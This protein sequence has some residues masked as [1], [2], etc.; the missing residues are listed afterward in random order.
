MVG[1]IFPKH[2]CERPLH[3]PR[4]PQM[5]LPPPASFLIPCFQLDGV[6]HGSPKPPTPIICGNSLP[7]SMLSSNGTPSTG[8]SLIPPHSELIILFT[9]W[10][11]HCSV[12]FLLQSPL[13]GDNPQGILY[14]PQMW[15]KITERMS[16][17]PKQRLLCIQLSMPNIS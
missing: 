6:L 16:V 3:A 1:G 2:N 4:A 5:N 13:A 9:A 15:P 12:K 7:S 8:L 10:S 11:L 14:F 17:P